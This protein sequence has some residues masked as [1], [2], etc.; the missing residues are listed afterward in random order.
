[1]KFLNILTQKCHSSRELFEKHKTFHLYFSV[2]LN[3]PFCSFLSIWNPHV[4]DYRSPTFTSTDVT[5]LLQFFSLS[6]YRNSFFSIIHVSSQFPWMTCGED[7]FSILNYAYNQSLNWCKMW[8]CCFRIMYWLSNVD[9]ESKVNLTLN[10][11]KFNL[12]K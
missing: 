3:Q 11:W 2:S 10:E 12:L 4:V 6:F 5:E 9:R 1:M 8:F 7:M